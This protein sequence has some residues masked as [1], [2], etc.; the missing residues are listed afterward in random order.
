MVPISG[1]HYRA[2]LW[3]NAAQPLLC[4]HLADPRKGAVTIRSLFRHLLVPHDFSSQATV[5]LKM[6]AKLAEGRRGTLTVLHVLVPFCMPADVPFGMPAPGDLIPEHRQLLE[7]LVT[8]VLGAGGPPVMCVSPSRSAGQGQEVGRR[9]LVQARND[10]LETRS[11]RRR[12]WSPTTRCGVRDSLA[13]VRRD[14]GYAIETAVDGTAALEWIDGHDFAAVIIDLRVFGA[15]GVAVLRKLRE[16]LR[17]SFPGDDGA[18]Q[19]RER[20]RGRFIPVSAWCVVSLGPRGLHGVQDESRRRRYNLRRMLKRSVSASWHSWF[21]RS[22]CA[23]TVPTPRSRATSWRHRRSRRRYE[24][25]ATTVTRT[26][27]YGLGTA[28]SRQSRGCSRTTSARGARS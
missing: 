3:E 28:K 19:R 11:W 24:R 6:A 5:A 16:S 21:S 10:W 7:R 8:R 18:R 20:H 12:S 4:E 25:P 17:R 13:E 1:T 22:S 2:P 26:R 15:N 23:S 27:L 14:A 9:R